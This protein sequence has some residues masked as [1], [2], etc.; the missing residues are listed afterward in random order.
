MTWSSRSM[1]LFLATMPL[2]AHAQVNAAD[3]PAQNL[4][5]AGTIKQQVILIGE[6]HGTE[7]IPAF[8]GGLVCSLLQAGRPVILALEMG[9]VEQP[10]LNRYLDSSGN[11]SDRRALLSQGA[12]ASPYKDGRTS[13]AMLALIESVRR[14]HRAGHQVGILA[15]QS[16]DLG[17]ELSRDKG[18][19]SPPSEAER[20]ILDRLN[21]H[22]MAN[23][24][25][26]AALGY[27]G[28]TV[29][30]LTGNLHASTQRTEQPEDPQR[31]PMGYL[32][33]TM[34][35]VFSIGLK[36][37]QG[38]SAWVWGSEGGKLYPLNAGRLYD[39]AT[40]VDVELDL[41]QIS[42]SPPALP[43]PAPAP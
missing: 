14:L 15:T 29:V 3:C 37:T 20:R 17:L 21:E 31:Q 40:P 30:A 43:K 12:W 32:L 27:S 41:G 33:K 39:D 18:S 9:G 8:T 34:L 38:G 13:E 35:P 11:V 24:I 7:Q 2:F 36:S 6:V 10:A 23:N 28:Y 26:M 16:R 4:I 22:G 25:A 1:A 19:R 42:A 5:D